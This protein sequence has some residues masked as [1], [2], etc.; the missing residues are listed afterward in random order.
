MPS[1]S[2]DFNTLNELKEIMGDDFDELISTFISDGKIQLDKLK[3]AID[4]TSASEIRRIA[5]TLKGSCANLGA[6]PLSEI[7]NKLE[8]NATD[9][10]LGEAKDLFEKIKTEYEQVKKALE[11]KF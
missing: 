3:L 8:R 4:S 1:N 5:H 10:K 11:E 9:N 2:I 6:H 7:C